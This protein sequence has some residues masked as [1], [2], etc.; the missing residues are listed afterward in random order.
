MEYRKY[1]LNI[2]RAALAGSIGYFG[3]NGIF[4]RT[5][6]NVVV[7]EVGNCDVPFFHEGYIVSEISPM[8]RVDKFNDCL[9]GYEIASQDIK[10]G[11]KLQ[12]ISYRSPLF[13]DCK[14]IT[15]I[16]RN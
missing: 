6:E 10:W 4:S 2:A 8:I 16:V 11:D 5:L 15:D 13:G 3:Y 7:S 12:S 14:V 9:R 1:V